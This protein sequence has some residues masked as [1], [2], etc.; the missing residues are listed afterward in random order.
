[1]RHQLTLICLLFSLALQAQNN[2]HTSKWGVTLTPGIL[3]IPVPNLGLMPGVEYK[4]SDRFYVLGDVALPIVSMYSD[5]LA[6]RSYFR[7]RT[8][9]RYM[10]NAFQRRRGLIGYFPDTHYNNYIG[11]QLSYSHRR[12]HDINGGK[13]FKQKD[14]D[15][16][17]I[18]FDHARIK[19]PVFTASLQAGA[20][21]E[22]SSNFCIDLF[23]GVGFRTV[24]TRYSDV[25]NPHDAIYHRGRHEIF[26]SAYL[27]PWTVI[28]PHFNG[29]IRL[30][31]RF[32]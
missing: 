19:S 9:A 17:A 25:T 10:F 22:L 28:R 5:S 31:Y 4:L 1:M 32:D 13:Y 24:N 18:E 14:N 8:E 29:G 30:I 3:S 6:D 27:Y 15:S 20:I 23:M 11:I 21:Y 12:F 26:P 2:R 16:A 7:F